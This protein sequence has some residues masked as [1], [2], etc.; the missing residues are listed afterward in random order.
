MWPP[1]CDQPLYRG[2]SFESHKRKQ[3]AKPQQAARYGFKG[4]QRNG[5]RILRGFYYEE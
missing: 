2:R 1:L 4:K 5:L 3:L